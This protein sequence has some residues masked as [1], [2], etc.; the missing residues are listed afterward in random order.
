MEAGRTMPILDIGGK[1][2]RRVR[3]DNTHPSVAARLPSHYYRRRRGRARAAARRNLEGSLALEQDSV[4]I[5]ARDFP[6]WPAGQE[7]RP[8]NHRTIGITTFADAVDIH[9]ALIE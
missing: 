9:R 3:P 6:V 4:S 2:G 5:G 8:L 7:V 1:R